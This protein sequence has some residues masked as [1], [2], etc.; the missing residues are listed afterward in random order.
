MLSQ[1]HCD[2]VFSVHFKEAGASQD[3]GVPKEDLEASQD[4]GVPVE[5][6]RPVSRASQDS[7]VPIDDLRQVSGQSDIRHHAELPLGIFPIPECKPSS[8]C[9]EHPHAKK[10]RSC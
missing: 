10:G 9:R 1:L 7:G 3:S 2:V 4:S 6:L 8:G 5:G